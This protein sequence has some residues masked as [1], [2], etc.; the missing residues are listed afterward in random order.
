MCGIAGIC[1]FTQASISGEQI[2][3]MTDIMQHRGPDGDGHWMD[4]KQRI[5]LGH[6]RLSIID[7]SENA[8]QPMHYKDRF[9]ITFNGE[10]YNYLEL[11]EELVQKGYSFQTNSDTEVLLALFDLKK[12]GC[13]NDIDG[14]F[15]FAIWDD[16]EENLFCA[17]DRFGEKPFH[18]SFY[19]NRFYF[20]SEMKALWAVGV[21]KIKNQKLFDHFERT[22]DAHHPENINETFYESIS[23]LE[24][25]HW[26]RIQTDGSFEIKKY[27]DI[28]WKKQDCTLNFQEACQEFDRLFQL[29]LQRRFRADVPVGT[30]LSGGL[31]SSSIVC[32]LQQY[33]GQGN[34][35]PLTFSA[36]FKG[37]KKDEGFFI[38]KVIERT[39]FESHNTWPT[40]K[41]M[42]SDFE[43]LCFHQ[44]E[45][46][47]GASIYAQYRVQ[48][49]AKEKQ[50]T[51]LIDG[52]GADEILAGYTS[53]Y[54]DYL[55]T[56]FQTKP[57]FSLERIREQHRFIDFHTPHTGLKK[58][59]VKGLNYYEL[60]GRIKPERS[61][62][63]LNEQLYNSTMRGPL[64][65]LLR[66]ADRNSMAHSREVRLPFLFHE[67]VEFCFSL[68][69]DYKLKLGWT[70]YIMRV[71][72]ENVLPQE[73]CWRKEKVGF[74][75]PQNQWLNDAGIDQSWKSYL[76]NHFE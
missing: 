46:F 24:H 68:P 13:L 2:R 42:A 50:V 27:F 16:L 12:E 21:P 52:Q 73:I 49:L 6:R 8:S 60:K 59:A 19:D 74:E 25:G 54:S 70:K 22:N 44:E 9:T 41:E 64:Q 38:D 29:G 1:S 39:Q 67:L 14:M 51:V 53:Y 28:D 10:I 71:T 5:A 69:D 65:D 33:L 30:S 72:F 35:T 43:R 62:K 32:N 3:L 47:G 76:L 63:P 4:D 11:K 18:Y 66:F 36:R 61:V 34:I 23:R 58:A 57:F 48:Q 31:D 15:A 37:F 55:K 40:G 7:L 20:A 17:R 56:L 45:P 26:M 75:P